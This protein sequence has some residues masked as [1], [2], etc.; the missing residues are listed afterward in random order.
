MTF[1]HQ[2][3]LIMKLLEDFIKKTFWV[4]LLSKIY[5][6][7]HKEKS[8]AHWLDNQSWNINKKIG[9]FSSMVLIKSVTGLSN[10]FTKY[11]MTKSIGS[12][13]VKI[14]DFDGL[15]P[16]LKKINEKIFNSSF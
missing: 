16:Y 13:L 7:H 3:L 9:S 11:N 4:L 1:T 8:V 12:S 6:F 5:I 14:L 10:F 15:S 2:S